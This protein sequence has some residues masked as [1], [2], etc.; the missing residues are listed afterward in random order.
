MPPK[1]LIEEDEEEEAEEK[2]QKQKKDVTQ[3][4]G[5]RAGLETD[6]EPVLPGRRCAFCGITRSGNGGGGDGGEHQRERRAGEERGRCG[7]RFF[8]TFLSLA[9]AAGRP[10]PFDGR[11]RR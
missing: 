7:V 2:R 3:G 5:G 8:P 11:R 6:V 1:K 10:P 4:G 9:R